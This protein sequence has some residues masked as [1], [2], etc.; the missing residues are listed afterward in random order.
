MVVEYVFFIGRLSLC[1]FMRG[2]QEWLCYLCIG[3]V[4]LYMVPLLSFQVQAPL[5]RH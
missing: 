4:W 5:P 1:E 3:G 2:V